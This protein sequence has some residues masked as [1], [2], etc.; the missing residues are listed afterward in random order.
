MSLSCLYWASNW[1]II[2]RFFIR[3]C[4]LLWITTSMY[5]IFAWVIRNIEDRLWQFQLLRVIPSELN[6][7]L[8]SWGVFGRT[9]FFI[10][11]LFFRVH[12]PPCLSWTT[13]ACHFH[14]ALWPWQV[15]SRVSWP[16]TP[17]LSW[18]LCWWAPSWLLWSVFASWATTSGIGRNPC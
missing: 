17:G 1:L 9:V 12:L 15:K 10:S 2:S 18:G 16:Q 14:L 5:A 11:T 4:W 6:Y 8:V 7:C 13:L 3:M